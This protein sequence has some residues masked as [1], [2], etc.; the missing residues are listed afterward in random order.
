[1]F[2][3]S[4]RIGPEGAGRR[5]PSL[6][7]GPAGDPDAGKR[8]VG[9]AAAYGWGQENGGG[10]RSQGNTSS[11]TARSEHILVL[12]GTGREIDN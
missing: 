12:A 4:V 2:W 5:Q 11:L 8:E 10:D 7:S 3:R 9:V 1:M 6:P